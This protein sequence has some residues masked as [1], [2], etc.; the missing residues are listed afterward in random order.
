MSYFYRWYP[1]ISRTTRPIHRLRSRSCE[2]RSLEKIGAAPTSNFM[3]KVKIHVCRKDTHT[4]THFK[5]WRSQPSLFFRPCRSVY[6][7]FCNVCN[8]FNFFHHKSLSKFRDTPWFEHKDGMCEAE[9]S[10]ARFQRQ[11]GWEQIKMFALK[12]DARFAHEVSNS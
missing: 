8:F 7:C 4:H 2:G 3:F 1:L 12:L 6:F 10:T 5:P 9:L 11:L